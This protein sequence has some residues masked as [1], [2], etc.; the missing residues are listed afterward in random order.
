MI[1]RDYCS[2][3]AIKLKDPR[4]IATFVLGLRDF[5]TFPSYRLHLNLPFLPI[6][7]FLP[8]LLSPPVHLGLLRGL[9]FLKGFILILNSN[10]KVLRIRALVLRV[11]VAMT[12]YY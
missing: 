6:L 11:L 5:A 12:L 9:Y 3:I 1:N 8:F 10:F 2:S 7:P 4:T